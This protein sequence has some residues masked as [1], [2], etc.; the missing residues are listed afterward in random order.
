MVI[1]GYTTIFLF[2]RVC[3]RAL[4]QLEKSK[5]KPKLTEDPERNVF[6]SLHPTNTWKP[7]GSL[8]ENA[9]F[10]P[11]WKKQKK[12]KKKKEGRRKEKKK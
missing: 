1:V 6:K 11:R 5:H 3:E 8:R 12:K 4:K 7:N 2:F 10:L 9:S